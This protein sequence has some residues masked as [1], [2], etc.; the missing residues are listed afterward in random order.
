M[1]KTRAAFWE[2]KFNGTVERDKKQGDALRSAGWRVI[3]VWECELEKAAPAVIL[4]ICNRLE[5]GQNVL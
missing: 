3:V 4:D 5:Q 1:P 2:S